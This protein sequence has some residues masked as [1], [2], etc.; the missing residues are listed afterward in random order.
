MANLNGGRAAQA[1]RVQTYETTRLR[2]DRPWEIKER[3]QS[4]CPKVASPRDRNGKAG[5]EGLF[6][7]GWEGRLERDRDTEQMPLGKTGRRINGKNRVWGCDIGRKSKKIYI[8]K[9]G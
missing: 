1:Q 7:E 6:W 8:R 3:E 4:Q 2:I 9:N 5:T